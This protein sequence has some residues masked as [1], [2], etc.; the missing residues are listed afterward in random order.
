MPAHSPTVATSTYAPTGRI[1]ALVDAFHQRVLSSADPQAL[2]SSLIRCG[3][4]RVSISVPAQCCADHQPRLLAFEFDETTSY[5]DKV[6][7]YAYWQARTQDRELCLD[8]PH[9]PG[10]HPA[11]PDVPAEIDQLFDELLEK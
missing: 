10:I 5:D 11:V 9:I 8:W 1:L 7:V 3:T 2:L 6:F 4:Q